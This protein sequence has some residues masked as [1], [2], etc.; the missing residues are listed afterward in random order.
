MAKEYI[1]GAHPEERG[2]SR[3]VKVKGGTTV[4]IAGVAGATDGQGRTLS[5]DF[6]GQVHA[7]FRNIS[8]ILVE[9]G[10]LLD[11]VVHTTVFIK[12]MK[13]GRLY[14]QLRKEYFPHKNGYP[15]SALIGINELGTPDLLVEIQAIA[16]IGD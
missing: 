13:Y 7:A 6:E 10:G 12:D 16:V 2:Y 1:K 15:T 11:D 5:G 9:A 3:A 4:Y 14:Q 8:D